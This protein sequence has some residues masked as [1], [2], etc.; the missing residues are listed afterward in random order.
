MV[1]TTQSYWTLYKRFS[2]RIKHCVYGYPVFCSNARSPV[3]HL[4][5]GSDWHSGGGGGG[6]VQRARRARRMRLRY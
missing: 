1:L 2:L 5:R 4:V 3:A 6:G